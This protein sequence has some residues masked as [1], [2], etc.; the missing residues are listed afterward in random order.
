MADDQTS[1][2]IETLEL[3]VKLLTRAVQFLINAS[4]LNSGAKPPTIAE[5]KRAVS[6]GKAAIRGVDLEQIK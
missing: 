1:K 5:I 3:R 6:Y 2:R 4:G